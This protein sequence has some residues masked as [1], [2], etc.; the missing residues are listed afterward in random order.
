MTRLTLHGTPVY[1]EG[2]IPRVGD[3]A[4]R[5]RLT[6]TALRDVELEHFGPRPKVLHLVPSLELPSFERVTRQL[7]DLLRACPSVL[8][9][10]VSPDLPFANARF[11]AQASCA[12]SCF[13]NPRFARS[14]GLEIAS[15][16]LKGLLAPAV[17]VLDARDRV[18]HVALARELSD[19][20]DLHAVAQA[21]T[22]VASTTVAPVACQRAA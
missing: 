19:L 6:T 13:R 1:T 18:A 2:T 17:F 14:W 5:A 9:L 20:P 10:T 16:P 12:L 7:A 11:E 4:P 3:A 22:T 8:L 15:G 21:A